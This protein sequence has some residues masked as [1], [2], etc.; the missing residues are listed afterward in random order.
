MFQKLAAEKLE[1]LGQERLGLN[2]AKE[3]QRTVWRMRLS[4]DYQT[5]KKKLE[6]PS[7]GRAEEFFY[8]EMIGASVPT[9]GP[10]DEMH[11]VDGNEMPFQS[12]MAS[13]FP[14]QVVDATNK[15]PDPAVS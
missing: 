13:C 10:A 7:E 3:I 6:A 15:R 9:P 2:S 8:V 14:F 1:K 4:D 5:Q 12:S 11:V